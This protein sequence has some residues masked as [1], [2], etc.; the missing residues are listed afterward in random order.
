[1]STKFLTMKYLLR[2]MNKYKEL[3]RIIKERKVQYLDHVLRGERYELLQIILEDAV[4]GDRSVGRCQNSWLKDLRRWFDRSS[5][6]IF[7]AAVSKATIA[8]W[9]ANLR[10]EMA[11]YEVENLRMEFSDT[12]LNR[13]ITNSNF[14]TKSFLLMRLLFI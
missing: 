3:L 10:K 6:E 7:R 5:A 2:R 12:M 1:M 14:L 13:F 9:I 11:K 8:I 4:Q